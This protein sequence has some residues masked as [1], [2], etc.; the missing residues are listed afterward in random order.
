MTSPNF[1]NFID[2]K[3][4]DKDGM[5]TDTWKQILSQLFAQ[6]QI[7]YSKE[8]LSVPSQT[9]DNINQLS[10]SEKAGSLFYDSDSHELKVNIN[11]SIKKI[12]TV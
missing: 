7:N 11:G 3:I 8:G 10:S 9:T 12:T 1:P 5:L 2:C 6:L 4:V